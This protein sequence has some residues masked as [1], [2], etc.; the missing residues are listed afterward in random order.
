MKV[1]NITLHDNAEINENIAACIGYFDGFHKGH[2]GLF[3]ATLAA[4]KNK[5]IKSAIITFNPDPWVVLKGM[6]EEEITHISTLHDRQKW[7]EK[8]GFDYFIELNFT[9]EMACL[10]PQIFISSILEPLHIQHLVCGFDFHF[11][12]MGKGNACVLKEANK[13]EVEE[14]K[15]ITYQ[16]SKI[17]STR[18]SEAIE[19][20]NME[21]VSYLLTRP[22]TMSG[23]VIHGQAKGHKIGFP[24][25]N[26]ALS[27]NYIATK[28]GVYIGKIKV[29]GKL[30]QT[31][32]NIGYNPTFNLRD[33]ISIEAYILDFE[34]D[35]YGEE[36]ELML[37]HFLREE[38][39][40]NSIEELQAV[41]KQN[42]IDTRNYFKE[43]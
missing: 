5:G 13:F 17:S 26:I 3:Y 21:L 7:A 15:E 20:G 10:D 2:Q 43:A 36:V 14:I 22:Y 29:R 30:Y 8:L 9:K 31:M 23:T 4:A 39:K 24:T 34:G 27:G 12:A 1:C 25:A 40:Y 18:I 42:V 37:Y 32:V 35:I 33:R 38:K 16:G 11:G 41:L 28:Q 6:K 19:Q